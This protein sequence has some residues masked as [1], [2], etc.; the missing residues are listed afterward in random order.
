MASG[1]QGF[2]WWEID[3]SFYGLKL[4]ESMRLVWNLRLP[5]ARLLA[6]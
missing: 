2:F 1:R 4:L 5:P 6:G 3:L